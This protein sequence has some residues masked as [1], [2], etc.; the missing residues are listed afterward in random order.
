[1]TMTSQM[2]MAAQYLAAAGISFLKKKD[3]DS[4]TNLG[5]SVEEGS[6]SSRGLNK[7]QETLSISYKN[8]TLDWNTFDY[9]E[10]LPLHGKTHAQVL[11]WIDELT[12]PTYLE[13]KYTYALHYDLPYQVT[14]DHVFELKDEAHLQQLLEHRILAQHTIERFLKQRQLNSEVRVWPHHFDTGGYAMLSDDSGQAVG[15]GMAIPDTLVD[16]HYFYISMYQGHTAQDVSSLPK[17]SIG[18]WVSDGFK[19]AILPVSGINEN[20]ALRFF[21]DAFENYL[22]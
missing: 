4:H 17:L 13:G 3:D 6:L 15:I 11:K 18:N 2:H 22:A 7:A 16:D 12:T 19:G 10:S 21:D 9:S 1:M 5:F 20:E 8:F 14:D